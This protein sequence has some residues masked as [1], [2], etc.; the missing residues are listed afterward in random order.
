M[1]PTAQRSLAQHSSSWH[2]GPPRELCQ[3]HLQ[4]PP[5]EEQYRLQARAR[6][7]AR[8][9]EG[10]NTDP[11]MTNHPF[12]WLSHLRGVVTT[13]SPQMRG[14][15]TH[16]RNP[17]S[18]FHFALARRF[19][20]VKTSKICRKKGV[21]ISVSPPPPTARFNASLFPESH[22][23]QTVDVIMMLFSLLLAGSLAC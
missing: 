15:A 6:T 8:Q 13:V 14:E 19:V 2:L 20:S 12:H 11:I 23:F 16:W 7:R 1:S 18:T 10:A 9:R 4:A 3:C 17:P 5:P 21:T 22:L